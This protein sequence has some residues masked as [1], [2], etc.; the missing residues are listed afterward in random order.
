MSFLAR[1][2]ERSAIDGGSSVVSPHEIE[3][4]AF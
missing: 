4:R 2:R 3:I 1:T